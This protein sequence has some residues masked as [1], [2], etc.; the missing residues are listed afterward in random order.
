M[1]RPFLPEENRRSIRA[2]GTL[3]SPA[4]VKLIPEDMTPTKWGTTVIRQEL[5]RL[6]A[7]ADADAAENAG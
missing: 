5:E 6:K 4:E 7:A 1:P 2:A 3:L